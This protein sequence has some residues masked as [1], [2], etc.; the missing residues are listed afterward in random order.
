MGS[1]RRMRP[2]LLSWIVAAVCSMSLVAAV[3]A[4]AV[5][6]PRVSGIRGHTMAHAPVGRGATPALTPT[7][8]GRRA[9]RPALTLAL[10]SMPPRMVSFQV[11]QV[12]ATL[13]RPVG[14]GAI[15]FTVTVRRPTQTVALYSCTPARGRCGATWSARAAGS[16]TMTARWSGDRRYGPVT[17]TRTIVVG[18]AS[19]I[20]TGTWHGVGIG[21]LTRVLPAVAVERLPDATLAGQLSRFHTTNR[22]SACLNQQ[23]LPVFTAPREFP[24]DDV[25]YVKGQ[26][27]RCPAGTWLFPQG[28]VL[29]ATRPLVAAADALFV[30]RGAFPGPRPYAPT[31]QF[32]ARGAPRATGP[33]IVWGSRAIIVRAPRHLTAG[34]SCAVVV[35]WYD[36]L[37]GATVSSSLRTPARFRVDSRIVPVI[38]PPTTKVLG[39]ATLRNLAPSVAGGAVVGTGQGLTLTFTRATATLRTVKSGDVIVSGVT[40]MTPYGLLR[41]VTAVTTQGARVIIQTAPAKL[42]DAITQGIIHVRGTLTAA[43]GFQPHV[44]GASRQQ[45]ISVSPCKHVSFTPYSDASGAAV[46]VDGSVCLPVTFDLT[47]SVSLFRP[48]HTSCTIEATEKAHVEVKAAISQQIKREKEI[49]LGHL[50]DFDVQVGPVPVIIVP[51]LTLNLGLD[52]SASAGLTSGVTQQL[53][54]KTDLECDDTDCSL[55]H[56]VTPDLQA[57]PVTVDARAEVSVSAGPQLKLLLYDVAG[58]EFGVEGSLTMKADTADN[59]WWTLTG[60]LKATA[61]VT[62]D[63]DALVASLH[64]HKDFTLL[65]WQKVLA[66]AS[67]PFAPAAPT[68]PPTLPPTGSTPAPAPP[69]GTPTPVGLLT[70]TDTPAATS[71]LTTTVTPAPTDL[72]TSTD[73]PTPCPE[74]VT[75]NPTSGP[76]G[77]TVT[78]TWQDDCDGGFVNGHVLFDDQQLATF[79]SATDGGWSGQVTI[80]PYTQ[81][82][83]HTI[84]V[85]DDDNSSK[86]TTFTS[87]GAPRDTPTD[88]PA[89]TNTPTDTS[90]PTNTP[91]RTATATPVPTDTATPTNTLTPTGTAEP[92]DT[93]LPSSTPMPLAYSIGLSRNAT[94]VP[95]TDDTGNHCDDC[96][97]SLS[98]PFPYQLYNQSFSSAFVTSNG[99]LDFSSPPD[100]GPHN[101]CLPDTNAFDAIFAYWDDLRTD[102]PGGG[103]FTSLSGTAPNRIF[104]IEWR[105]VYYTDTNP[106]SGT[107]QQANFE[108]RLY[109]GTPRFDVIYGAVDQGGNP[110]TVGVQQSNDAGY[111]Q[112]ECNSAGSLSPGLGLNFVLNSGASPVNNGVFPTSNA[113]RDRRIAPLIEPVGTENNGALRRSTVESPSRRP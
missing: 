78:V 79:T 53:T 97:T 71:T 1:H 20:D 98:L 22:T 4:A 83:D 16:V 15:S 5:A 28:V 11:G 101:T 99:Q 35:S 49:E 66:Q 24:G 75:V 86:S 55:T 112:Y 18:A 100:A 94:I 3:P 37:T 38:I 19:S 6:T 54:V 2:V 36:R 64:G 31:V 88:T 63:F 21:P 80:S 40:P 30:L 113:A 82:G 84:T 96:S 51:K 50:P 44:A 59:P 62:F 110:G 111:T 13:S 43:G 72:P 33:V 27:A 8:S 47:I 67:G 81:P 61:G 87:I 103:V 109:E 7:A 32:I 23:T 69:T 34:A 89:P 60:E 102:Q 39:A 74:V 65:D 41:K 9:T 29:A 42:T 104:N 26:G 93:P 25:V 77:S 70:P 57:D 108:I 90:L 14:D 58:P 95:G 45:S 48:V 76:P 52:G 56:S 106:V 91:T 105:A 92:T 17:T 107:S 68:A 73:T 12:T 46:T 10:S 85:Q